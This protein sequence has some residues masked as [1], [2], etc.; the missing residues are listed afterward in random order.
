MQTYVGKDNVG[1]IGSDA[2]SRTRSYLSEREG[3][4]RDFSS[5]IRNKSKITK[6]AFR[7]F[8]RFVY[9]IVRKNLKFQIFCRHISLLKKR[10]GHQ[11]IFSGNL[12]H[13]SWKASY[14][15]YMIFD[16]WCQF[17]EIFELY[18]WYFQKSTFHINDS[19]LCTTSGFRPR[20]RARA[21]RAPVFLGSFPRQ[22]GRCAPP[23]WPITASLLLIRPTKIFTIYR[24]WAAHV[25]GFFLSTGS[26]RLW[27]VRSP[28]LAPPIAASLILPAIFLGTNY[29]YVPMR[30]HGLIFFG[31]FFFLY[32]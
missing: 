8:F 21:L 15:Y 20:A 28:A 13:R 31:F 9:D 30:P 4:Q 5:E 25:K 32:R 18:I 23:P 24:T 1:C 17:T 19:P 7:Y 26:Q 11:A 6:G 10:T 16:I 29:V 14:L 27:N 22:T 12:K 2:K 3:R